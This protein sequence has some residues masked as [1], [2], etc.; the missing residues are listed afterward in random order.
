[1]CDP[2]TAIILGTVAT[3]MTSVVQGQQQ[4]GQQR[5]ASEQ[6]QQN[7]D[8]VASQAEQ[9]MN[10]RNAKQ[11]NTAAMFSQNQQ[12]AQSGVSS[13]LLTGP[14]GVDPSALMLGKNTLLGQ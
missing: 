14:Q 3:T 13:T 9:D 6:A 12:E 10:R 2:I 4:M 1:M 8:R 11:P 7:A 5:R